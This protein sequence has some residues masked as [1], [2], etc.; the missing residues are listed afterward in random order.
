M[1]VFR[2]S[3][4]KYAQELSG[5]GASKS[6]NRWNSKGTE[7]IYT[8]ESRAL[9]MA[10]VAVH[11][12]LATLPSGYVMME[13]DI[14]DDIKIKELKSKGL[15]NNWNEYPPN[16]DTQEIGDEFIDASEA[17]VLKVPSAV[18]QG[19]CNYLINPHHKDFK[20]IKISDVKDFPFDRRI[21]K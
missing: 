4:K 10:E 16:I 19:D 18:V 12:T 8:A 9:A 17:C 2:L 3:K 21:F 13:I 1:K 7:I 11:L 6:E 14:P 5:K 20:R 15:P